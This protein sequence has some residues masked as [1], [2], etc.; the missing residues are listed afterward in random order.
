MLGAPRAN[1]ALFGYYYEVQINTSPED[2]LYYDK[3]RASMG[4]R[5][6]PKRQSVRIVQSEGSGIVE[7]RFRTLDYPVNVFSLDLIDRL[8]EATPP[9]RFSCHDK[10]FFISDNPHSFF[11]RDDYELISKQ[12]FYR[13]NE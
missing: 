11:H 13:Q 10:I 12:N 3:L 5:Y 4:K 1:P 9:G 6:T 2:W 8:F 7:I